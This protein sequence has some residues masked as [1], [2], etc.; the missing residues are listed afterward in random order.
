V[1]ATVAQKR[2]LVEQV[3][4]DGITES[5]RLAQ[6]NIERIN[7]EIRTLQAQKTAER[8]LIAQRRLQLA[9]VFAQ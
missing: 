7:G 4:I 5:I 6:E 3:R 8:R 9:E 1:T 2:H